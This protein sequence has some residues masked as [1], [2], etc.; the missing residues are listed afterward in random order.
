MLESCSCPSSGAC[1]SG[2]FVTDESSVPLI[3]VQDDDALESGF[4]P[5]LKLPGWRIEQLW[6]I[7]EQGVQH[8]HEAQVNSEWWTL[9]RRTGNRTCGS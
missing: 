5:G 3:L 8:G 9:W 6:P 4:A 7:F 2:L 1:P